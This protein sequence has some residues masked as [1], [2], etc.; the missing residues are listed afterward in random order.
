MWQGCVPMCSS[1]Y[2]AKGSPN[3]A[4]SCRKQC[5]R[6]EPVLAVPVQVLVPVRM[7]VPLPLPVL[8][9]APVLVLVPMPVHFS[10]WH[11]LKILLGGCDASVLQAQ[12][13]LSKQ[14]LGRLEGKM[15]L[16]WE[17]GRALGHS[18]DSPGFGSAWLQ[19]CWLMPPPTGRHMSTIGQTVRQ[20]PCH[21]VA[22]V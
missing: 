2:S 22:I 1:L 19:V 12:Q 15:L 9:L 11:Q 14:R 5:L 16:R 13:D 10:C 17:S 4:G 8:V 7:L 18:P 20:D 21:L 6:W 3:Q